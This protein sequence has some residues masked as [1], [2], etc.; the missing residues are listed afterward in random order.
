[1][2]AGQTRRIEMIVS[3]MKFL[4]K[5]TIWAIA[6]LSGGTWIGQ[7]CPASDALWDGFEN[8]PLSARPRVWWHWMNGN[9][10]EG[11][12]RLDLEWMKRIGIGG[13]QNFDAA[14]FTPQIVNPR[15]IYMS[16]PWK[17]AFRYTEDLAEQWGLELAIASSPGWSES[18]GPWVAPRDAM[19]KLVWSE[20]EISGGRHIQMKLPRPPVVTGPFQDAVLA[21]LW[22]TSG[23]NKRTPTF[24]A[25][26]R[27]LAY[28]MTAEEGLVL[29]RQATVSSGARVDTSTLV[30][31][32][33]DRGVE[34][35]RQAGSGA[36][37]SWMRCDFGRPRI[38]SAATLGMPLWSRWPA[39]L[40]ASDDGEVFRRV[41]EFPAE[42][43]FGY[44]TSPQ[45]T[46]TFAPVTARYLRVSFQERAP[47]PEMYT[48]A[49]G[50]IASGSDV[51]SPEKIQITELRFHRTPRVHRFEEKAGFAVALDYYVTETPIAAQVEAVPVTQVRDLTARMRPDGTLDWNVPPGRWKVLRLG[52]SLTGK[53]NHPATA[54]ATGLEVDKLDR[55][56][57]RH[58]IETYLDTYAQTVGAGQLGAHG[59]RALPGLSGTTRSGS[60]WAF[61]ASWGKCS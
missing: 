52:Y 34:V 39:V 27:V 40:E 18:G 35:P 54:E 23:S 1:M 51:P 38:V 10:T 15:L 14:L 33:L 61:C 47:L 53:E 32:R 9:V 8:P 56:A 59:V 19:K 13:M 42:G 2:G 55:A 24:Y 60:I 48:S 28:P 26:T 4:S 29:P 5:P 44:T 46:V 36:R 57:V 31:G 21:E 37:V 16:P 49:P 30:D 7:A 45:Y 12:I 3:S 41:A 43:R 50:A 20:T 17:Q 58:Y 6:V 11:G 25:D 22:A